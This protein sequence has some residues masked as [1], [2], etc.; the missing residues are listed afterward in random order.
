M[1]AQHTRR[2]WDTVFVENMTW[3]SEFSFIRRQFTWQPS[4]KLVRA[5]AIFWL[6]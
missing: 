4:E 6:D 5:R 3:K 1:K 2:L